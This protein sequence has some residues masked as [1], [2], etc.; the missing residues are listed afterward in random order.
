MARTACRR[1]PV[2]LCCA[3]PLEAALKQMVFPPPVVQN[4]VSMV[5]MTRHYVGNRACLHPGEDAPERIRLLWAVL[6]RIFDLPPAHRYA[7]SCLYPDHHRDAALR[8]VDLPLDEPQNA[9]PPNVLEDAIHRNDLRGMAGGYQWMTGAHPKQPDDPQT[10]RRSDEMASPRVVRSCLCMRTSD[11]PALRRL[12]AE[13]SLTH[14]AALMAGQRTRQLHLPS[15][16]AQTS[17]VCPSDPAGLPA[18]PASAASSVS[19]RHATRDPAP[20]SRSA[21]AWRLKMTA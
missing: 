2:C 10:E 3:L 19:H 18:Y 20:I 4:M 16:S 21:Q 7:G 1:L 13:N 17:P 15:S 5:R 14:A 11:S 9:P 8:T 12:P 6:E